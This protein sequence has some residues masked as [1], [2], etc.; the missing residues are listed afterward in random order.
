MRWVLFALFIV[1]P[2]AELAVIIEVGSLIGPLWTVG[3]LLL[4]AVLGSWLLRRE[5]RRAW[6]AFQEALAEQRVPTREVADGALVILGAALMITPGFLTDVTGMLCLFPPSRAVLRRIVMSTVTRRL[7]ERA[8]V[9][10]VSRVRARRGPSRPAQQRPAQ[11][12]GHSPP[13]VIEGD[14]DL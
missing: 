6:R 10:Q 4:S 1:V 9:V 13:R 3:L 14:V 8:G 11:G 7:L 2:I 5:G 12:P